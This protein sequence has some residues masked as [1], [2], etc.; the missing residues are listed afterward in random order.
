[1]VRLV[2]RSSFL[3]SC[4]LG[5]YSRRCSVVSAGLSQWR[6]CGWWLVLWINYVKVLVCSCMLGSKLKD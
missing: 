5:Q 4:R 2:G 6:Q 1:M 3:L